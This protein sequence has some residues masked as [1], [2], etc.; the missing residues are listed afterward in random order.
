MKLLITRPLPKKI[1]DA[2]CSEFSV[3]V[4]DDTAP[5]KA[6]ELNYALQDFD[7]VLPTLGDHFS[8]EVFAGVQNP[9]AKMLANFG[10]GIITSTWTLRRLLASR[11]VIRP[12]R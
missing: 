12:V 5:L 3:E 6:D 7:V 8:S 4:R 9:R 10:S 2:A 11:S 1:I